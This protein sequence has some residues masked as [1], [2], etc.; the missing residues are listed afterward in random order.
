[1][2]ILFLHQNPYHKVQYNQAVDHQKHHVIYCG[3][4]KFLDQIPSGLT[5]EKW[6]IEE[7]DQ[8]NL[9]SKI[10]AIGGVDRIITRQERLLQFAAD[11]RA[12]FH[13]QGLTPEEA[14]A[15]R[16]KAIMKQ[17]ILE[18][19]IRAPQDL[20]LAQLETSAGTHFAW[21]GKTVLKPKDGASSVGIYQ[22]DDLL[23]ALEFIQTQKNTINFNNYLLEEFLEGPVFH[24]DGF[25]YNGEIITMLANRYINT[26]LEY[27][28]GQPIGTIQVENHYEAFAKK[29]L[30]ALG[31]DCITFHLEFI[32]TADGPVFLECAAR[33]GG[34]EI[35]ETFR[36]KTGI[37]LH[38]LDIATQIAG[39]LAKE[40]LSFHESPHTY[41]Q[42]LFP[43]NI[44]HDLLP[45]QENIAR[46]G[47]MKEVLHWHQDFSK[48]VKS[49]KVSYQTDDLPLA[50]ILRATSSQELEEWINHF[51]Q[52]LP[53]KDCH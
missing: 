13:L 28:Q 47:K 19:G 8:A 35:I 48:Q 27:A 17:R 10:Q 30:K 11:V 37:H 9:I 41:G 29:C 49:D 50:G 18:A 31:G 12:F 46:F 5:C 51:F 40:K 2:K 16:N 38:Q 20:S 7:W 14:L 39:T 1:M 33:A 6:L 26:C 32:L 22:F 36:L 4:K 15:Y 3:Q 24:L 45:L 43:L 23:S 34:S 44:T 42:V 52:T 53:N 25:F 21:K